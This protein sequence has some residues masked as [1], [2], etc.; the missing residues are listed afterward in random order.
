[1]T[2][3][4][5]YADSLGVALQQTNIL[6]DIREDLLNGRVYLPQEDL[7]RFGVDLRIDD[8]GVLVDDAG[9][10]T[11]LVRFSADRAR[12]WYDDGLRLVPMLDRRS[13]ACC[14]AMSGIYRRLLDRIA[15]DPALIRDRR[16]SLS[17]W[18]KTGVALRSLAGSAR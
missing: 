6:R 11:A 5:P 1:M 10:L 2:V 18:A 15:A 13:A 16:L 17:A 9:A 14:A 4:P 12:T 8:G 7:D 3:A